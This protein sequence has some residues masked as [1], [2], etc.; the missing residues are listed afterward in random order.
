MFAIELISLITVALDFLFA[1]SH[2][3]VGFT[4][5]INM[6]TSTTLNILNLSSNGLSGE[7]PL[8]T[9]SCAVLELSSNEFERNLTKLLKWGNLEEMLKVHEKQIQHAVHKARLDKSE[10]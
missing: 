7:L 2:I 10:D 9:G 1:I 5:L 4:G 6:I 8:L 3:P